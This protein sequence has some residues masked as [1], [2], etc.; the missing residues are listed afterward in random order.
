[1]VLSKLCWIHAEPPSLPQLYWLVWWL[2]VIHSRRLWCQGLSGKNRFARH[3]KWFPYTHNEAFF[4]NQAGSS[5]F[6]RACAVAL[7]NAWGQTAC[8]TFIR[9]TNSPF[10]LKILNSHRPCECSQLSISSSFVHLLLNNFKWSQSWQIPWTDK[11][12]VY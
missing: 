2:W 5:V 11:I 4:G 12:C 7:W 3:P 8:F 10:S 9:L 6:T 1:M